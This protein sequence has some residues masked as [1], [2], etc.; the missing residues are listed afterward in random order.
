MLDT[1]LKKKTDNI[2][3]QMFRQVFVGGT[4]FL[5]DITFLYILTEFLHIYYLIS[6]TISF[7]FGSTTNYILSTAWVFQNRTLK[8]K[9]MEFTI[10][11][12]I[13]SIGLLLNL[14]FLWF[15]TE[16]FHIYYI[17]SKVIATIIVFFWNFFVRRYILFR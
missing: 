6:A 3:I 9:W 15:F 1:L 4:A 11:V 7:I 5:V 14:F 10:F 17:L 13:G 8:S 2:Y 16:I 12:I